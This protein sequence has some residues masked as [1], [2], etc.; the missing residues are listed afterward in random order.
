MIEDFD[1]LRKCPETLERFREKTRAEW[2]ECIRKVE[3]PNLTAE[4][5]LRA[6]DQAAMVRRLADFFESIHRAVLPKVKEIPERWQSAIP[7]I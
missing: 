5:R 1:N 7:K 4:A 6:A 3:N 2:D